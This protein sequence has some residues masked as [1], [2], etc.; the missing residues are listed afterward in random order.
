MSNTEK[1]AIAAGKTF[2]TTADGV[3]I[4]VSGVLSK[5][6]VAHPKTAAITFLIAG[7]GLGWLAGHGLK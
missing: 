4:Q 3:V 6:I 5:F 1:T 7:L 2:V